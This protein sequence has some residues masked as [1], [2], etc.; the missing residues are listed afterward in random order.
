M[1]HVAQATKKVLQ[2]IDT[3]Q[4]EVF[5]DMTGMIHY[6]YL[7]SRNDSFHQLYNIFYD[8]GDFIRHYATPEEYQ[9]WKQA[10]DQAVIEKYIAY[11]WSTVKGWQKYYTDF[12]VTEENFH[13]VSMFVPQDQNAEH[14]EYYEK[15]NKDITQMQ[16]LYAV[17]E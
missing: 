8:A 15:F 5:P 13:G 10:L 4:G 12:E 11:S 9:E 1:E 6:N 2:R 17:N 3:R 7:G 14:G 16:W